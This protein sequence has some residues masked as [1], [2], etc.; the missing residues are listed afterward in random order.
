MFGLRRS[1]RFD[2]GLAA[3]LPPAYLK[4][5]KEWKETKPTAVHYIPKSGKFERDEI[6]GLVRAVQNIPFP[7][8]YPPEHNDG[9]WGGEG[10]VKGFQKRAQTKR[11]VPHMWIPSLRRSVVYSTVLNQ[12]MSVIVTDRTIDLIHDNLGFDHYLLKV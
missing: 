7:I 4:F 3:K 10:V 12:Y 11:R 1:K 5:Y 6:T 8:V 9:I 2:K